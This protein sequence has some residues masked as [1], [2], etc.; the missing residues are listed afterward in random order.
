MQYS[1]KHYC[2]PGT[3]IVMTN[4]L[5]RDAE[6]GQNISFV[7]KKTV[8]EVNLV[9]KAKG[10]TWNILRTYRKKH[11][12]AYIPYKGCFVLKSRYICSRNLPSIILWWTVQL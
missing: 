4:I 8:R 5:D 6:R 9:L 11:W 10:L 1:N 2:V 12:D 7:P 3:G